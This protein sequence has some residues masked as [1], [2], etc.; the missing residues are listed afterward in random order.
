MSELLG[1]KFNLNESFYELMSA[2]KLEDEIIS[3]LN[4]GDFDEIDVE[5]VTFKSGKKYTPQSIDK[6]DDYTLNDLRKIVDEFDK[7]L[8]SKDN[9]F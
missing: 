1:E 5:G 3:K 2:N 4:N 8:W 6:T 9:G 7:P